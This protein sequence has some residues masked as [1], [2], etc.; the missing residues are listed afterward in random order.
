MPVLLPLFM[1]V[2]AN[3]GNAQSYVDAEKQSS[4][5]DNQGAVWPQLDKVKIALR[6]ARWP[7]LTPSPHKGPIQLRHFCETLIAPLVGI[8][9]ASHTSIRILDF[10]DLST[11]KTFRST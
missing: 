7:C 8:S 1:T 6:Y 9:N 3:G 5:R 2:S 10:H 11:C 4:C